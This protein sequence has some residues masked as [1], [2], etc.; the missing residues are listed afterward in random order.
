M[1]I[2]MFYVLQRLDE[3]GGVVE[4]EGGLLQE[5]K[6]ALW[7]TQHRETKREERGAAARMHSAHPAGSQT[8]LQL[9]HR[10]AAPRCS[11]LCV[12]CAND[13]IVLDPKHALLD[14][15]KRTPASPLNAGG[16]RTRSSAQV[17]T[18]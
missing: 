5:R 3:G 4:A 8:Y 15:K 16:S 7:T 9:E 14:S 18:L 12:R 1:H 13:V 17:T 11:A 2:Y 10:V 6:H